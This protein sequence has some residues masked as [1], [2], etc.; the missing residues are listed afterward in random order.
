MAFWYVTAVLVCVTVLHLATAP[1]C[2][3]CKKRMY[4]WQLMERRYL[5]PWSTGGAGTGSGVAY[6]R[7]SAT[8]TKVVHNRCK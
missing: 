5:G 2:P 6:A 7:I 8:W 4:V 3:I 1:R